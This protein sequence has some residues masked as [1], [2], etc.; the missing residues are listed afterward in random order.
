VALFVT[1]TMLMI[2]APKR[3]PNPSQ[4]VSKNGIEDA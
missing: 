1:G 4:I 2:P 3:T